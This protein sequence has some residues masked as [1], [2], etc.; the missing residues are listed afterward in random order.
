M[1]NSSHIKVSQQGL[2]N[3][4]NR[5]NSAKD[6]FEHALSVIETTITSLDEVWLGN[7]Q[8]AMKEKYLEKKALFQQFVEE[9]ESYAADMTAYRDDVAQRDQALASQ[10][11]NNT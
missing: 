2:T 4:I 8:A 9:I 6:E 3:A 11:S 7:S 1:S 5:V 10:I